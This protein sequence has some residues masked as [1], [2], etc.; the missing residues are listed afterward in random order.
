MQQMR[1]I[2]FQFAAERVSEKQYA[3]KR[4]NM[5]HRFSCMRLKGR[6][7]AERGEATVRNAWYTMT[8][9]KNDNALAAMRR[10]SMLFPPFFP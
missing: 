7:I 3:Q 10:L 2:L 8:M 9:L 1:Y 4:T 6:R 5:N